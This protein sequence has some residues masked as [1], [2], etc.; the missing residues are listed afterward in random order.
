MKLNFDLENVSVTEF[1]VGRDDENEQR[2]A[3]VPVDAGVQGALREM[4]A[5]TW[6]A[7]QGDEDGP[8][9]YEP[10]EKHGA[11]EY[12]YLPLDDTLAASVR[13]LHGA[14]GLDLNSAALAEPTDVFCYFARFADNQQRH[15]T[16]LRRATQFKGVLKSKNRLVR[17]L[18]DTLKIIEDTVFRLDNDFDLLVDDANVHILR[19]KGFEFAGKLQQAILDAVP[20]NIKTIGKDLAFVEF[21]GIASYAGT[22]PRAARYLAS[23]LALKET[24]SI[25]KSLLRKLCKENGVEITEAK[26]KITV[27]GGH[28]MGFLEVLDRRRYELELVKGIARTLQGAEPTEDQWI[29]PRS[30]SLSSTALPWSPRRDRAMRPGTGRRSF[31]A[32]S[33]LRLSAG[34]SWPRDL[35]LSRAVVRRG[36]VRVDGDPRVLQNLQ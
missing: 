8:V 30:R 26:G 17:I 24:K 31:S 18:D 10:A 7:M 36:K 35:R 28:E 22:H 25:D 34:R 11:T 2:F 29:R 16:A 1:G 21:D 4:A 20:E 3:A 9:R 19:P 13:D 6:N 27:A 14:A 23:I 5:A 32:G 15:L 12:L 33:P